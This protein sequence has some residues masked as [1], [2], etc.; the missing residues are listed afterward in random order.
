MTSWKDCAKLRIRESE[1]LKTVLELYDLEIHQREAGSDD[2]RLQTMVKRIEQNLRMKNFDARNGNMKET[3]WSRIQ[4]QSSVYKEF[5]EIVGNG[6][7]TGQCVKGNNCSSR[8][9][10]DKRGKVAPS[11]PSPNS[12]M[13]QNERKTSRTRSPRGKKSQRLNVS[14]ALEGLLLRNLHHKSENGWRFGEKCSCAY[15]KVEEQPGEKVSKEWLQKCSGY[16]DKECAASKIRETCS[17][18]LLVKYTTVVRHADIRDQNPSLGYIC[19][20]ELHHRGPNAPKFED[21]SQEET[22]WQEQGLLEA[23]WKLAKSVGAS[24]SSILLT[25]GK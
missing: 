12:F 14:S 6:K 10:M 25:F 8:H 20:G 21:R 22:E 24:K 7:P 9:D 18:R 17:R 11:N 1:K 2:H 3:P 4:G 23:S 13:Q 19:P 5:L 16:V 15:R